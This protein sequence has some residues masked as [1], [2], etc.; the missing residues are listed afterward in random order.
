MNER[1]GITG[2]GQMG[3][4]IAHVCA[5]SGLSVLLHDISEAQLQRGLAAIKKNMERQLNKGTI[6]ETAMNAALPLIRTVTDLNELK[7]ST[8]IIE[9]APENEDIKTEIF[10]KLDAIAGK[11]A[12]LA[13]NTSSISI[14]KLAAVTSRP[15]KV[16]GLHFMNPVPMMALVE[17]IR[18]FTT[19]DDTFSRVMAL[20]SHIGKDPAVSQDYPAFIVNRLLIPMINEAIFALQEAISSPEDIDKAMKLGAGFPMGPLALADFIG[21]DTV[22]AIMKVLL[23]GFGDTKYRPAPLLVKLVEAGRLGKKTGHGIYNYQEAGK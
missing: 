13:S 3:S 12:I 14:T 16:I 8:I 11:N 21:L 19:S 4:G 6:T 5:L 18:G 2:A 23:D 1:I 15:D 7:D 9:A 10:R 17:V 20:T 22:L